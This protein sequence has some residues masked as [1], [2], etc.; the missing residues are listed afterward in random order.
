MLFREPRFGQ[1]A[2][3][4]RENGKL[5]PFPLEDHTGILPPELRDYTK[6]GHGGSEAYITNEF[7]SAYVEAPSFGR[8][9]RSRGVRRAGNLRPGVGAERR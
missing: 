7:V 3:I 1:L 2:L 4:S 6:R 9:L 8:H 5:Q